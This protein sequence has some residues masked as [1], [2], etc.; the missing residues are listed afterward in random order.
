[1]K[2]FLLNIFG[3][4]AG[5]IVLMAVLDTVYTS[6]YANATP[7]TKFQ[8]FRSMANQNI[9]YAFI[10]SSRVD[11][12]IIPELIKKETG[13]SSINLGFQAAKL[14]DMYT[15]L[16]LIESYNIKTQ[17]VFIQMDYC[18][19]LDG[20]SNVMEHELLPFIHDNEVISDNFKYKSDHWALTHVPFYRYAA[21]DHMIGFRELTMNALRMR[22]S[23]AKNAGYH[24]LIGKAAN[25]LDHLPTKIRDHNPLVDSLDIFARKHNMELGYFIS[26][27]DPRTKNL[28]YVQMLKSKVPSLVDYSK[29]IPDTNKFNNYLHL[30]DI[31][32]RDFTKQFIEREL[33]KKAP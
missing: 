11:N 4:I 9:D 13:K 33:K 12:H 8:Y 14:S 5:T 6:I 10:G 30:N 23:I 20:H 17:G 16:K 15:I 7:R 27:Y 22:T 29:T 19:D 25:P 2:R 26:P 31:G 3:F 21:Y 32:A 24:A 1:M 28:G 18:Y